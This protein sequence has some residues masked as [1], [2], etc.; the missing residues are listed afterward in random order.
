[1][2]EEGR[3]GDGGEEHSRWRAGRV[4]EREG[5]WRRDRRIGRETKE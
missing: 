5:G 3:I 1:M 2:V 4:E